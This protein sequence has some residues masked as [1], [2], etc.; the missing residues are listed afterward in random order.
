MEE[1]LNEHEPKPGL[2]EALHPEIGNGT[3]WLS[4]P[5][6]LALSSIDP[7]SPLDSLLLDQTA[8][9]TIIQKWSDRLNPNRKSEDSTTDNLTVVVP[10]LDPELKTQK[11]KRKDKKLLASNRAEDPL[12][13]WIEN[14]GSDLLNQD[15]A[16]SNDLT[17]IIETDQASTP[18]EG[19]RIRKAVKKAEKEVKRHES[20]VKFQPDP[21]TESNLSPY[22]Q[23]LKSLRG[24]EYV[25]P[26]EDDFGLTQSSVSSQ[27]GISETFADL[28]VLQGYKEQA[29]DMYKLL[30][31]K[32]PEKSSFFAAK[33]EALK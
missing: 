8:R 25:H 11:P 9:Q 17:E 1:N 33:I 20:R 29:I 24:S 3:L 10:S 2:P 15:T 19:K 22:T 23:W 31:A 7:L 5:H 6:H 27:D 26:Y 28:L 16:P 32:Y 14:T 18:K 13:D 30:M 12:P 21:F 4:N